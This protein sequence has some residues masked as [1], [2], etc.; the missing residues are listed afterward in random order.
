VNYP[1]GQV[2]ILEDNPSWQENYAEI[3]SGMG[4]VYSVAATA[5]DALMKLVQRLYHVV[6]VDLSL[7]QDDPRNRDGMKV[8]K[9]INQMGE[10][11]QGIVST[12]YAFPRAIRDIFKEGGA[13]DLVEKGGGNQEELEMMIRKGVATARQYMIAHPILPAYRSQALDSEMLVQKLDMN[14]AQLDVLLKTI[15][16]LRHE[17]FGN[18]DGVM[19]QKATLDFQPEMLSIDVPRL[20]P[21][22]QPARLLVSSNAAIVMLKY[23]DRVFER[24]LLVRI[25]KYEQIEKEYEYFSTHISEP[26]IFGL[27]QVS[28]P[29]YSDRFGGLIYVLEQTEMLFSE[30][31]HPW[32]HLLT[33]M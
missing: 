10:G 27:A 25:S 26:G 22:R 28:Q 18:A 3:V 31:E 14:R 13:F 20:L 30:F 4:Y 1:S 6:I 12:G 24:G 5:A 23:W 17:L 15:L 16:Y 2:L 33:E 8:L 32:E 19:V 11:T 9:W 7:A 21:H 29:Y